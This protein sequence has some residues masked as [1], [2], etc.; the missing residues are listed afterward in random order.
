MEHL[1][2]TGLCLKPET[3]SP[4]GGFRMK[5]V[6]SKS[7]ECPLHPFVHSADG[8]FNLGGGAVLSLFLLFGLFSSCG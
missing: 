8:F 1:I 5:G 6:I 3:I 4:N 2:L 7:M